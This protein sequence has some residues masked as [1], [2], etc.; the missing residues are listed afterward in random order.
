MSQN[1]NNDVPPYRRIIT[2]MDHCPAGYHLRRPHGTDDWVFILTLSGEGYFKGNSKISLFQKGSLALIP[3]GLTHDYGTGGDDRAWHRIWAH[4]HPW[5]H[6]SELLNWPVAASGVRIILL[7][8][9]ALRDDVTRLMKTAHQEASSGHP[10]RELRALNLLERVLFL[11]DSINPLQPVNRLD[12]RIQIALDHLHGNLAKPVTVGA[13]AAIAGISPS[14]FAH[15]FSEQMG[16]SPLKYLEQQ[17]IDRARDLLALT[18]RP[19]AEIAEEVGFPSPYYF[20]RRF[21]TFTGLAPR[22]YRKQTSR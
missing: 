6:W 8:D 19:I 21:H 14:R 1:R 4:C 10:R 22:A 15:L 17:R 2:G 20:S 11:C 12:P 13:L 9:T 3:Q 5:P 18:S 7:H 16:T